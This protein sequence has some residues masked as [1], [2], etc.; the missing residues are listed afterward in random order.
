MT[1]IKT[2]ATSELINI[3]CPACTRNSK[4]P[5]E[6]V[7]GKHLC[8]VKCA[9]GHVFTAELEY[10]EKFRKKVDFPGYYEISLHKLAELE[11]GASVR[12][13][14]V[15]IDRKIPNCRIV[16][17]SRGGIGFLSTDGRKITVGDIVRLRFNLDN[18]A[19]TEVI[20]EC[21]VLHIQDDFIGSRMLTDNVSLG[22]YLLG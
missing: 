16:D 10:R 1:S 5:K 9:C 14:S 3:N 2:N 19:K 15:S 8:K 7:G 22:F 18:T 11:S 17:I 12:W 6:A 4:V 13:E 20:Q 21:E